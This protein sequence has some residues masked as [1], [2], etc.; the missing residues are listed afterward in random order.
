MLNL[1][2]TKSPWECDAAGKYVCNQ[3]QTCCRSKVSATGWQC[4]GRTS[5]TCCSDGIWACSTGDVCN[6]KDNTCDYKRASHVCGNSGKACL[7]T[8]TCCEG[9][10]G[11]GCKP[12]KNGVCCING[13]SACPPNHYC[14]LNVDP[15]QGCKAKKLLFLLNETEEMITEEKMTEP[16]DIEQVFEPINAEALFEGFLDGI[17]IFSNLPDAKTCDLKSLDVISKDINDI[18]TIV[19]DLKFDASAISKI[20]EVVAKFEEIYATTDKVVG[21][22]QAY[23]KE[24]KSTLKN[25]L[26]HV[27]SVEWVSM[28]LFHTMTDVST[29]KSKLHSANDLYHAKDYMGAGKG[30]G[31]LVHEA[32]L[33]DFQ[34]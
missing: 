3:N 7:D 27:K 9:P 17:Q 18:I 33:W 20:M 10:T 12:V 28:F 11:W 4:H 25:V 24:I 21:P 32:L 26:T 22:C 14:D 29:L 5:G 16:H 15:S 19:K 30:Y 1:V 34:P 8:Q 2:I 13:V 31:D 6:S 23:A